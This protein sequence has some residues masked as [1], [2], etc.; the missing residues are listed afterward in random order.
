MYAFYSLVGMLLAGFLGYWLGKLSWDTDLPNFHKLTKLGETLRKKAEQMA[1]N[2]ADFDVL[3]NAYFDAVN[4][5]VAGHQAG[6][7]DLSAEAQEIANAQA[8]L[9]PPAP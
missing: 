9:S 8:K 4:A 3:L 7:V 5:Y 6:T 1:L 2:Q